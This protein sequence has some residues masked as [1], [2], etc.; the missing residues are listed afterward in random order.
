MKKS[1]LRTIP[2]P[3]G[4]EVIATCQEEERSE[5]ELPESE[6]HKGPFQPHKDSIIEHNDTPKIINQYLQFLSL[7][8][9]S[10]LLLFYSWHIFHQVFI[11]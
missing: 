11:H 5:Y 4:K 10:T 6:T 7:N 8:A 9:S 2:F 1:Y 3:S